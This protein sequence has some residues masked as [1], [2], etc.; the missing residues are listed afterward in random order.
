MKGVVVINGLNNSIVKL[1]LL[2][3]GKKKENYQKIDWDCLVK[4]YKNYIK[5]DVLDDGLVFNFNSKCYVGKKR[6]I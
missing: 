4:E 5:I 2:I 1:Y 3:K 6:Y